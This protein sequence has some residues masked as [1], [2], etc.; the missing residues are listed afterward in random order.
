MMHSVTP[1]LQI[2]TNPDR[3][4]RVGSIHS[5]GRGGPVILDLVQHDREMFMDALVCSVGYDS[6][7]GW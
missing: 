3:H 5:A 4:S 6:V 1:I 2:H 7:C